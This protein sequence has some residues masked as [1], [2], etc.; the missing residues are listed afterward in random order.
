MLEA[1]VLLLSLFFDTSRTYDWERAERGGLFDMSVS[2]EVEDPQQLVDLIW[3]DW[4]DWIAEGEP[5][6]WRMQQGYG[7]AVGNPPP[8]FV[9]QRLFEAR[10]G[11][12]INGC[13]TEHGITLRIPDRRTLLHETAHALNN[14]HGR[15]GHGMDFRCI[16]VDLY[17]GYGYWDSHAALGVL[18]HICAALRQA[19]AL[20]H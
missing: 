1:F 19:D 12:A 4:G 18:Q 15:I 14:T 16:A 2:V 9:S 3:D 6:S 17:V 11:N 20:P 13:V 10:C 5:G 7:T 8:V